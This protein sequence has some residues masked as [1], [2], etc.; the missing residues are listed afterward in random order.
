VALRPA[1]DALF[2]LDDALAEVVARSREPALGAIKLAWWREQ[3]SG[4]DA[5]QVPAEPRLRAVAAEL[6][7]R[8]VSGAAL[9]ELTDGWTALFDQT[10]DI[11]QIGG[12]GVK[13]FAIAASVLGAE[14]RLIEAAGRLYRQQQVSRRGLSAVDWPMDELDQLSR[15]RFDKA[16]RPLTGLAALARRDARRGGDER[17][18]TPGRSW[19]LMRHRLTGRI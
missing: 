4:L 2:D 15:H 8:R 12:G 3:L 10:P 14:D 19:A 1:F 11:E 5:G 9:A 7:P 13:L 16:A 17:E 6:L 18:A